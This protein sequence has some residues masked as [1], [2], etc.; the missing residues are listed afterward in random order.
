[1]I[2]CIHFLFK[3]P[4]NDQTSADTRRRFTGKED[5][6]PSRGLQQNWE[7]FGP[8]PRQRGR[9]LTQLLSVADPFQKNKGTHWDTKRN[10]LCSLRQF[11]SGTEL[12]QRFLLPANESRPSEWTSETRVD[13]W[14]GQ[15]QEQKLLVNVV[16]LQ[17]EH[18][19]HTWYFNCLENLNFTSLR[20]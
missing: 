11:L 7:Q 1:M 6:Q 13:G 5:L 14:W 16:S 17:L 3:N 4:L 20:P 19:K 15:F 2:V 10:S 9:T 18:L 12:C 8:R